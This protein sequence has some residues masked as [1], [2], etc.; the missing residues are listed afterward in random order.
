M[1]IERR[2]AEEPKRSPD[3]CNRPASN[4]NAD[5]QI[6]FP[7]PIGQKEITMSDDMKANRGGSPTIP[8]LKESIE[9]FATPLPV[10][11]DETRERLLSLIEHRLEITH[12]T[13]GDVM[14]DYAQEASDL[15]E[16]VEAWTAGYRREGQLMLRDPAETVGFLEGGSAA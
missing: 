15:L 13:K 8:G 10:K 4:G 12:A 1:E 11:N 14:V 2:L 9:T 6:N 5:Y 7:A 16:L 3:G